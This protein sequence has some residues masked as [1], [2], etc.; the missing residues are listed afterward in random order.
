MPGASMN[1]ERAG[2]QIIDACRWGRADLTLS[3]PAKLAVAARA[4]APELVADVNAL[5]G[6]LLPAAG[7][8]GSRA[9]EGAESTSAWSPS[10]LTLLGE[11]AALAHNELG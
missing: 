6:R 11:R 3:L 2:R 7:G 5:V 1:A 9:V 4:L 8:V 10:W